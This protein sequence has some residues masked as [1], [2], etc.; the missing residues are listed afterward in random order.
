MK[1]K[2]PSELLNEFSNAPNDARARIATVQALWGGIAP[3]TVWRN[4]KA[5]HIPAPQKLTP[6]TATWRV[7]DLRNAL[8]AA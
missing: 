2:T 7:G 4:V 1:V 6:N 3:C 5:G 8:S